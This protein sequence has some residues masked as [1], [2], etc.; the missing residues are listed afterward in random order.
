MGHI[1]S[2]EIVKM[3]GK[4]VQVILDWPAPN[5]ILELR[6]FLG[7]TNYYRKFVKDYSKKVTPLTDLLKNDRPW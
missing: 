7:L 1:I 3:D 6:S 5:K 2:K 4:K